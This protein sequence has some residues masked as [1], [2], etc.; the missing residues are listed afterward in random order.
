MSKEIAQKRSL[1]TRA[2]REFF[3]SH[4]FLEVETPIMTPTVDPEVNL[5]PFETTLVSP[6]YAADG[7]SLPMYLVPSPEFQMKKLLGAG[8]G[9]IYTI[10]KVF[11][12]GEFGGGRH[13]V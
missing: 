9:N 11:R 3:D 4:G 7:K 6:G 13:N 1:L 5:T 2:V 12:N 10:T 8:F